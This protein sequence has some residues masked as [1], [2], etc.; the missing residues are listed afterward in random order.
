MR[1]K[2]KRRKE[3]PRAPS[4]SLWVALAAQITET[5]ARWKGKETANSKDQSQKM[6]VSKRGATWARQAVQALAVGILTEMDCFGRKMEIGGDGYSTN[7]KLQMYQ[8]GVLKHRLTPWRCIREPTTRPE[9]R[10]AAYISRGSRNQRAVP[11]WRRGSFQDL[12]GPGDGLTVQ[13]AATATVER[14]GHH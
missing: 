11:Q 9:V 6:A 13:A 4:P 7:M 10:D 5:S 3:I 12:K 14:H 2:T 8:N 1:I